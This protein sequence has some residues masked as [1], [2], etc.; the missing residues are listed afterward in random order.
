MFFFFFCDV[1]PTTHQCDGGLWGFSVCLRT[2]HYIA[3][4]QWRKIYLDF[5]RFYICSTYVSFFI[6][7]HLQPGMWHD[8]WLK[9][10]KRKEKKFNHIESSKKSKETH[11]EINHVLE[12]VE[13]QHVKRRSNSSNW[14]MTECSITYD[15]FSFLFQSCVTS[16]PTVLMSK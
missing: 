10:K 7:T 11:H 3:H 12:C 4:V 8:T 15:W 9:R 2:E 5:S 14:R 16:L 13:C 6:Y 1:R